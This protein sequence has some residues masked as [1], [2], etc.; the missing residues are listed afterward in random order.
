MS[1][2]S[3][4][5]PEQRNETLHGWRRVAERRDGNE[6]APNRTNHRVHDMPDRVKP[7]NL[8]GHELDEVHHDRRA[9]DD[10]VVED[11]ELRRKGHP[12]EAAGETKDGYR[13]I[14]VEPSGKRKAQRA[15]EPGK[16]IHSFC[17]S[18]MNTIYR[19]A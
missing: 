14:E 1:A 3:E 18:Q 15:T 12:V 6:C 7:R 10:V 17:V 19:D 2:G 8:V 16:E 5:S 9:D 11:L 4:R 13:V